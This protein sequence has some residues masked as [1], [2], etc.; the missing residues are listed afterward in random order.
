MIAQDVD[1]LV[2]DSRL[3]LVNA[4]HY[5]T[6]VAAM[7]AQQ[8][9]ASGAAVTLQVQSNFVAKLH[10]RLAGLRSQAKILGQAH[11]HALSRAAT[12]LRRAEQMLATRPGRTTTLQGLGPSR[13]I[14]EA[15][16]LS[17]AIDELDGEWRPGA[18][19]RG[20]LPPSRERIRVDRAH[21]DRSRM[22]TAPGESRRERRRAALARFQRLAPRAFQTGI[23]TVIP[24]TLIPPALVALFVSTATNDFS[25]TM[26][27]LLGDADGSS[28]L[29]ETMINAAISSAVAVAV[30]RIG[31]KNVPIE[32]VAKVASQ[33]ISAASALKDMEAE[34]MPLPSADQTWERHMEVTP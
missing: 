10:G 34:A 30:N 22:R 5:A 7:T 8:Y 23:G 1:R 11:R 17:E 31:L 16:M 28:S 29:S 18:R 9:A 14:R 19:Q 15:E 25:Q 3:A 2:S 20:G 6:K 26:I 24:P 32:Q 4:H 27:K 13:L 12:M 21:T 33:I